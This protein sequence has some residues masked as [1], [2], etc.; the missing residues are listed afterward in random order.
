MIS[1]DLT[2]TLL[3]ALDREA[4]V[5]L[6][7]G[8][9]RIPSVNPQ[10]AADCRRLGI[11]PGEMELAEM[12]AGRLRGTGVEV[13]MQEVAAGRPNLIARLK[14]K[15][16]GP[17]LCFN[18][19]LDTVGAYEMGARA[20]APEVR[21]GR[22]YGRGAADVKGSLACFM[23]VLETLAGAA[24]DL[25]GDVVLTAV[26]GE[27]G[28]PSGTRYLL[29]NGFRADGTIVGEPSGGRLFVGQRGGQF[30][31]LTTRGKTAHGSTPYAGVNAI[32]RMNRLLAAIPDIPVLSTE[33][34]PYGVPS[35]CIGTIRGGVRTNVVPD[36]CECT[37]DVR[38][39]PGISPEEVLL[40]FRAY[41]DELGVEGTVEAEEQ[42]HPAYLTSED[43]TLLQAAA[44]AAHQLGMDTS[45]Q[46]AP[47]W[48]DLA[49][50]HR[51]GIPALIVGP[52]SILQAHSADEYV[53]VDDLA[54]CAR[55]YL[56]TALFFC[57]GM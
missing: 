49:Y 54:R 20:F 36:R 6:A 42:G 30:V 39:P 26:I 4:I 28:P 13:T 29:C 31:R 47:Y 45:P 35:V 37:V 18:G 57:G 2:A 3:D 7:S 40:G 14:G 12:M 53:P 52:G 8:L 44:Q 16:G 15:G 1:R 5:E 50:L 22:L 23:L 48:S 25:P 38:L 17:T 34:E 27:E 51:A 56:L 43:S 11:S 41:M 10:D 32:E 21:D 55:L 46:L 24:L 33:V 19:H 9:I